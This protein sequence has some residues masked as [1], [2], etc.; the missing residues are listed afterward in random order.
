MT[1]KTKIAEMLRQKADLEKKMK[2]FESRKAAAKKA[3]LAEARRNS[4]SY[5]I[6]SE[7]DK[8][9]VVIAAQSIVEKLSKMAEDLAKIEGDD[10]MPMMDSLKTAFGAQMADTFQKVV[11]EQIRQAVA[12]MTATKDSVSSEV[13]KL[14][15]VVE[16]T[17]GNDMASM[18][19]EPA[20]PPAPGGDDVPPTDDVDAG[21]DLGAD[22]DTAP[23][24]DDDLGND[25]TSD[26]DDLFADDTAAG[27]AGRARKESARPRGRLISESVMDAFKDAFAP[28][29]GEVD[30]SGSPRDRLT[31][32]KPFVVA[33]DYEIAAALPDYML[34]EIF[35]KIDDQ[36]AEAA[37]VAA[38]VAPV[39][40][41]SVNVP[42]AS[43]A[44]PAISPADD[45]ETF[46][47]EMGLGADPIDDVEENDDFDGPVVFESVSDARVVRLFRRKLREG[48]APAVVAQALAKRF[49]ID[50][51]DVVA[52]IKEAKDEPCE[53][54]PC[55]DKP[56]KKA[57]K[58][59]K[60]VKATEG[61]RG[62]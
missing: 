53:D 6:E 28:H 24:G 15:G 47:D 4:L 44:L 26:L 1:N 32:L 3:K 11:G 20:A 30:A 16:G 33:Q 41:V 25:D 17:P 37:S 12:A 62:K 54:K 2:T 48:K 19:D 5:L 10:V 31:A 22:A 55:E 50:L 14:E 52:I 61:A 23:A 56:A 35:D 57:P 51:A 45:D 21:A 43:P 34:Q 18:G 40:P 46:G 60:S 39:A 42:P 58:K 36:N 49:G 59:G 29:M 38:P 7:L 8:A 9:A 27:P 13:G